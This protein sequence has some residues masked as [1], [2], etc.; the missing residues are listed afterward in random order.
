MA[1]QYFGKSLS[2]SSPQHQEMQLVLC[3]GEGINFAQNCRR[4][5][6]AQSHLRLGLKESGNMFSGQI[7][8][9]FNLFLEKT[10]VD[11]YVPKIE[12]SSRLLPTKNI[13][14]SL[15]DGM[16]ALQICEGTI[17]AEAYVV[18]LQTYAAVKKSTFQ[19]NPMSISA[20]KC[21]VSF[22]TS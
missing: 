3:Q 20:G 9:C 2:L 13:K 4:V 16:G 1:R 15:C 11:I 5:L 17:D 8:P 6:W 12:R 7:S 18:I 19:R 22:Y 10:D 21:Q 14:T